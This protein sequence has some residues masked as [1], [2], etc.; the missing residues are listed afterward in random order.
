MEEQTSLY[1][2]LVEELQVMRGNLVDDEKS[3]FNRQMSEQ[4]LIE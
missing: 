4:E 3:F 2:E 1:D